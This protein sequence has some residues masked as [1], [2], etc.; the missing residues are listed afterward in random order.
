MIPIRP[1]IVGPL[2]S[3]TTEGVFRRTTRY[4]LATFSRGSGRWPMVSAER[5]TAMREHRCASQEQKRSEVSP[6]VT[7]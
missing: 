2:H 7:S 1:S 6:S 5:M 4:F 3:T